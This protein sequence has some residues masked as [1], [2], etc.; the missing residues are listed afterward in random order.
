M[1]PPRP[2]SRGRSDLLAA[3]QLAQLRRVYTELLPA[4]AQEPHLAAVLADT[5]AHPGS[6]LRA[7]LAY[8][9]ARSGGKAERP[10]LE[11]A[12]AIEAFHSASLLL[13]DLPAMDDARE[14]RGRPCPHLRWGEGSTILAAL[15]LITRGYALLW[16]VLGPRE[17]RVRQAAA[18]LVEAS[19]G[20]DGILGGQALDLYFG[21]SERGPADVAR[22]A[23][24]KTVSLV[25]LT[26]V[27]PALVAECPPLV[28][29]GLA[30]L[31]EA[32]GLAYQGLDDFKD[33]WMSA[34]LSGK[35]AGRDRALGRPNLVLAL[36]VE[37]ALREIDR[38][39]EDGRSEID[40][41]AGA[42]FTCSA[43]S[44]LGRILREERDG[45][46]ALRPCA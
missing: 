45:L 28:Q 10:A 18:E 35:S 25:R 21:E 34:S 27:L 2:A 29:R 36:G 31:A 32:W 6:L 40:A 1:S 37:G 42:G 26:L 20:V 16:R 15:A 43:L 33:T 13:D 23:Q 5:I 14:R 46:T 8:C 44:G 39:L 12:V 30:R 11:L 38:R 4:S 9:V 19:L 22:V 7:Q 17:R 3:D 24:G 41:L